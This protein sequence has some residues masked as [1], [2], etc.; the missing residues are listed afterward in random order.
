MLAVT[1]ARGS[2]MRLTVYPVWTNNVQKTT[3]DSWKVLTKIV[4]AV[5]VA[6]KSSDRSLA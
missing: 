4:G 1:C 2:K 5:F 6:Q 3:V